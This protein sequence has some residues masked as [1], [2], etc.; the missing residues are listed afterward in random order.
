MSKIDYKQIVYVNSH[1]RL[2]GTN[3]NF[4]YK[5]SLRP[6]AE[7]DRVTLLQASIPKSY[8]NV[9]TGYNYFTLT[10]NG[11]TATVSIPI[12]TY[13]R[14]SLSLILTSSLNSSSPRGWTYSVTYPNAYLTTDTGKY[15]YTVSGNA[16][17]QPSFTFDTITLIYELMGFNT[18]SVN[19][20]SANI[21]TSSNVVNLQPFNCIQIHSNI[22]ANDF[23]GSQT[24]ADI[25]A[26]VIANTGSASYSNISYQC[27]EPESFS[28]NLSSN[29][30]GVASFNLTDEDNIPIDLNGC[31]MQMVLCFWKKNK[32]LTLLTDFMKFIT[33]HF[34]E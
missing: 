34:I 6:D 24:A 3:S 1:D 5:I 17:L 14:N 28:H 26:T 30:T 25:L 18:N 29:G 19:I 31:N 12:G 23:S 20:F 7:F 33:Q 4:T 13:T 21:L 9:N 10:E 11:L 2:T 27:W 32:S 22:V 8:Y 16:G 15:T